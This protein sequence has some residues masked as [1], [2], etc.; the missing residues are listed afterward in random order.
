MP[1]WVNTH[2]LFNP[3][4]FTQVSFARLKVPQWVSSLLPLMSNCHMTN[5]A[6]VLLESY[7]KVVSCQPCQRLSDDINQLCE[8]VYASSEGQK[9]ARSTIQSNYPLKYLSPNSRL[10]RVGRVT[11]EQKNLGARL[12][13]DYTLGIMWG[14]GF[15]QYAYIQMGWGAMTAD[16]GSIHIHVLQYSWQ[17]YNNYIYISWMLVVQPCRVLGH[18]EYLLCRTLNM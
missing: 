15:T 18:C 17:L 8:R 1:F 9:L 7:S 11:K 5:N 3:L 10:I 2:T 13:V 6:A 16:K 4:D 12:S 14:G